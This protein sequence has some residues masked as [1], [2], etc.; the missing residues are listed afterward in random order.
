MG[1]EQPFDVDP[2]S[3]S[4]VSPEAQKEALGRLDLLGGDAGEN[5]VGADMAAVGGWADDR[6]A[7]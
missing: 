3:S 6:V 5:D 1:D 4:A 2:V 7:G